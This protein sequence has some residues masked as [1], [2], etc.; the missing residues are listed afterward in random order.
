MNNMKPEIWAGILAI[1]AGVSIPLIAPAHAADNENMRAQMM[2]KIDTDHDGKISSAEWKAATDA[3]FSRTDTNGDGFVSPDEMKA[4]AEKRQAARKDR[5]EQMFKRADADGDG[6]LSKAEYEA[7]SQKMYERMM[8]RKG[9]GQDA[10][11][12]KPE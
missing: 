5:S 12:A 11:P 3:R 9:A 6:K 10:Q 4:A 2:A 8:S 7:G 1:V